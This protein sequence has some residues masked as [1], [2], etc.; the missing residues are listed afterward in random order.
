MTAMGRGPDPME[1]LKW[2]NQ[3]L[4]YGWRKRT[5][6]VRMYEAGQNLQGAQSR[7][8][9]ARITPPPR[10]I[11]PSTGQCSP[12]LAPVVAPAQVCRGVSIEGDN[13]P[14]L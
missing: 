11:P 12:G 2:L 10:R 6:K 7:N 8:N 4:K 9:V 13:I 14:G 5:L 1:W 3:C